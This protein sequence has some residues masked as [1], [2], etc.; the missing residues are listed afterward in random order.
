MRQPTPGTHGKWSLRRHL[1]LLGIIVVYLIVGALF[2]LQTPPWQAPDEP[3]HYNVVRQMAGGNLPVIEPSDYDESYR[4]QAVSN[5]FGPD[6]P[7]EPLTY[8]D[9]QPPLYYLLLTPVFIT[10]GGALL[11]L[12]LAS[13]I[14]VSCP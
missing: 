6:Y 14:L 3:A 10:F 4:A 13:L 2:A 12:R 5:K 7:I 8:E 1:S 11:P 9:W